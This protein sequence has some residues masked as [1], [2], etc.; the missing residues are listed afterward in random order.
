MPHRLVVMKVLDR[1]VQNEHAVRT[2]TVKLWK[3][4]HNNVQKALEEKMKRVIS[5]DDDWDVIVQKM[6]KT[7]KKVCGI[8]K[9]GSRKE[10]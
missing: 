3:L 9:G 2:C 7:M 10:T 8:F 6:A 4:K 5:K 1:K